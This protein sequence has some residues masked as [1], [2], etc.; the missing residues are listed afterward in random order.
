MLFFPSSLPSC[1]YWP[2]WVGLGFTD[3]VYILAF[4]TIMLNTDIHNPSVKHKMQESEFISN[5]KGI[6]DGSDLPAVFLRDLYQSIVEDEIKAEEFTVFPHAEK[7]GFLFLEKKSITR[8]IIKYWCII[9]SESDSLYCYKRQIVLIS[10]SLF[11]FTSLFSFLH[12]FLFIHPKSSIL[13]ILWHILCALFIF[14]LSNFRIFDL[15]I[16]KMKRIRNQQYH[17]N[18]RTWSWKKNKN[19]KQKGDFYSQ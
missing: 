10:S 8:K 14:I 17:S 16:L 19:Q 7:R 6:N 9:D 12:S 11:H 5:N 13:P 15:L 4:S 3:C 2:R 1:S 18:C